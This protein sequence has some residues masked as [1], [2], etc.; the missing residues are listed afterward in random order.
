MNLVFISTF[1]LVGCASSDFIPDSADE[2]TDL[3]IVSLNIHYLVPGNDKTDWEGRKG[4]VSAAL[5]ELDADIVIFQEMETFE[6]GHSPSRNIQ[7][8]WVLKTV[9]EYTAGAVGDPEFYPITQPILYRANRFNL[10]DQGF[11]FFSETPDLI[12]SEPWSGSWPAFVTWVLLHDSTNDQQLYIY[13][14]HLDAFSRKNRLKGT[15]LIGERIRTRERTTAEVILGG[16]FNVRRG[17]SILDTLEDAN[18]ERAP[19]EGSTYHF[20]SGKNLYGAI[21]HIYFSPGL[22]IIEAGVVQKQWE[23]V[24]P[25]DH[26]P[27]YTSFTFQE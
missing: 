19:I 25:S 18:L 7:L 20:G 23:N 11:F 27:I 4:A 21:D 14:V 13:N 12:Y 16:D 10:M 22:K 5:R 26:H 2:N 6:G 9:E 3:S 24:W 1:L 17:S 8:D 15:N